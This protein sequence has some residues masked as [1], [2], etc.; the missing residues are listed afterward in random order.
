L[1]IYRTTNTEWYLLVV[2]PK[3][4]G[5]YDINAYLNGDFTIAPV[6]VRNI[7]GNNTISAMVQVDDYAYFCVTPTSPM[8]GWKWKLGVGVTDL[9]QMKK[10]N[11]MVAYQSRLWVAGIDTATQSSTLYFSTIDAGGINPDLWSA[12]DFIKVAP[13]EGGFITA[14]LP[15]NASIL[16]FKNDGTWRFTYPSSPKS[17]RVDK[18]SGSV[19]ASG[20]TAVVEFENYVYTYDQGRVYELV[21]NNYTQLNRF[22]KFEE[23]A[24]SVDGNT[25]GVD[26]SVMNRRLI[27]RYFNTIYSYAIDSRSWSQWNSYLGTPGKLYELPADSNSTVPSTYVGASKALTQNTGS[28]EIDAMTEAQVTYINSLCASGYTASRS[29]TDLVITSTINGTTNIYLNG[30]NGNTGYNLKLGPGQVY[31]L[32]G[33][34]TRTTGTL[35]ARMHYQMRNGSVTT[36]DSA[37]IPAG[38][39][40]LN[41]TVPDNAVLGYL[42]LHWTTVTSGSI[43]FTGLQFNRTNAEAPITLIKI[44]DQYNSSPT[45]VEYIDCTM[46]TKSY[47]YQTPAALK[48]LFWWGADIKT[49]RYVEGKIN[50]VAVKLPPKWGDLQNYTHTQLSAGTFGNPLSFLQTN[51]SVIDGGDPANAQTENGRIFAKF[52]KSLRFRQLSFELNM[53]TLGTK[54]TGPVKIHSLTSFVLPKEKVVDKFT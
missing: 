13:G 23:D 5:S 53:S 8:S 34:N 19:G 41:F 7:L 32:S 17:G 10:G 6:F 28:N 25:P 21:N 20:P 12:T 54:A 22:V 16:I 36:V 37:S 48:R 29:G 15:L 46:K 30:E 24:T 49:T 51:L 14:L 1:G 26:L 45:T 44:T 38:A 33:S 42:S 18:V 3:T 35:V 47:D 9:T 39:I 40:N 31:N 50:P 43:T 11:C 2:V 4:N 52:K 27:L